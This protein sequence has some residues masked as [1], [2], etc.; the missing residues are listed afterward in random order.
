MGVAGTGVWAGDQQQRA[1][2]QRPARLARSAHRSGFVWWGLE[3]ERASEG[4]PHTERPDGLDS[5]GDGGGAG[6]PERTLS[7]HSKEL[8]WIPGSLAPC[9]QSPNRCCCGGAP[10]AVVF[11]AAA[12]YTRADG[13]RERRND[14][15]ITGDGTGWAGKL[16]VGVDVG[17][18]VGSLIC[19]ELAGRQQSKQRLGTLEASPVA[20]Q[21]SGSTA[22][23]VGG[24]NASRIACWTWAP[25]GP[26]KQHA[27]PKRGV[28]V[29]FPGRF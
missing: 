1:S 28:L 27:F 12:G 7:A 26:P 25:V 24:S 2:A 29:S 22:G 11:A 21:G 23:A 13:R 3:S 8:Q 18:G 4:W 19:C 9:L 5:S 15:W 16:G 17:V 10:A 14:E 6:P 20:G